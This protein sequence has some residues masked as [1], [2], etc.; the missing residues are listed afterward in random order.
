L[1]TDARLEGPRLQDGLRS[2][3]DR[4]F[5]R[6]CIDAC[7]STNDSVFLFSTGTGE[8]VDPDAF[9]KALD[10]V[11]SDLAEQI[12]RDAEGATRLVRVSIGGAADDSAAAELG[13]AIASSALWRAAAGGGDPNW[14]RVLAAMGAADRSLELGHLEL[15][16]GDVCVFARGAP[17]GRTAFA[18][19]AMRGSEIVVACTVGDGPGRATVLGSD[20]TAEY[21]RL[22]AE[23]TS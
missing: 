23:G 10:G 18:A 20:L 12:A 16:I 21:V 22:N 4:T 19:S 7:E 1:V 3:V 6:L 8:R 9:A 11:C 2:A 14:G 5:N 17:T 13:R 15:W